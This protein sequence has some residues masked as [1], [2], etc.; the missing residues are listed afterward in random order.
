M[1][2][3]PRI[4]YQ[5]FKIELLSESKENEQSLGKK[6]LSK[7][8]NALAIKSDNPKKGE[9]LRVGEISAKRDKSRSVFTYWKDALA[10]GF[11]SSI[12]LDAIAEK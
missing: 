11:L 1:A 3:W 10:S 2:T 4:Q 9:K 7:A 12:G 5:D 6:V 8:A